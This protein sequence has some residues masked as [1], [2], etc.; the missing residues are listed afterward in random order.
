MAMA[1]VFSKMFRFS[2]PGVNYF[3]Y[4]EVGFIMFNYFS[5]ATNN[6]RTMFI[7]TN[8]WCK[9]YIIYFFTLLSFNIFTSITPH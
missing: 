2:V 7:I 3:V 4:F 6:G 9:F 1:V 8:K 5:E